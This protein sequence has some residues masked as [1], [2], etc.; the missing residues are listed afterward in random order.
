MNARIPL[1]DSAHFRAESLRIGGEKDARDRNHDVLD[2]FTRER[3]G[4]V[5]LATLDDVRSAYTIAQAYKPKL[6]RYERCAILQRAAALLRDPA[7]PV[8][9]IAVSVGYNQPAQFAKAFRRR[10]GTSPTAWRA[11]E[12]DRRGP[13]R[14]WSGQGLSAAPAQAALQ[15]A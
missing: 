11:A 6:S 5:P 1:R 12:L 2:P 7:R 8:A 13:G 15:V 10:F 9:Q 4:T 3:V 14:P